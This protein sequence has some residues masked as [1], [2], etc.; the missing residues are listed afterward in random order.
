[1]AQVVITFTI[2]PPS[3]DVDLSVIEQQAKKEIVAFV[4][5]TGFK[6]EQKPIAF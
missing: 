5:K 4:G 3:P 1:M 2:M 6:V